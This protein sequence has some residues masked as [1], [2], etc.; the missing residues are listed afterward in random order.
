LYCDNTCR[1]AAQR[2]PRLEKD[3]SDHQCSCGSKAHK[4]GSLQSPYEDGTHVS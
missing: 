4:F 3:A 2:H 1:M